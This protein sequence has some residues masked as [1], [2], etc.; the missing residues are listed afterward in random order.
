MTGTRFAWV[1]QGGLCSSWSSREHFCSVALDSAVVEFAVVVGGVMLK[2]YWVRF[3]LPGFAVVLTSCGVD[4]I[5]RDVSSI[6]PKYII[7]RTA[8]GDAVS[9]QA[10]VEFAISSDREIQS[11]HAAARA[12]NSGQKLTSERDGKMKS[13]ASPAVEF[14]LGGAPSQMPTQMSTQS[15][16]PVQRGCECSYNGGMVT[17]NPGTSVGLF[18]R[19]RSFFQKLNPFA[20][21]GTKE[22]PYNYGT[23]YSEGQYN[24]TVYNQAQP[25]PPSNQYPQPSGQ[26][27]PVPQP[28]PQ[29]PTG[30]E[31]MPGA[32]TGN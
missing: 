20:K 1:G 27:G 29:G 8:L 25:I 17:S 14:G 9:N 2:S 23:Q 11:G 16:T 13:A 6:A 22:V 21:V 31:P 24:Y 28:Q 12:F 15:K 26:S 4:A 5:S 10:K 18:P 30:Q 32:L 19:L 3:I 7:A